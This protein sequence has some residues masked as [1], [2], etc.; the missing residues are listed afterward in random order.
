TDDFMENKHTPLDSPEDK[1]ESH[2]SAETAP[3]A[4]NSIHS[5][6]QPQEMEVHHHSHTPRKEF[7]HYAFEFFMLFLAV[8]CGFLAEYQLEHVIEHNR[9]EQY[10]Y[11]LAEDI[12]KDTAMLRYSI[13]YVD[14][15]IKKGMDSI[16]QII[17][18]DTYNDSASLLYALH[19]KYVRPM[20]IVFIDRT[21]QQLKNAGG[22]RLIRNSEVANAIS[23]YW[24]NIENTRLTLENYNN[25]RIGAKDIS[26]RIFN[27]KYYASSSDIANPVIT[28]T[29]VL[30]NNEQKVIGEY[31]N[32]VRHS[33]D[34]IDDFLLFSLRRTLKS[35]ENLLVLVSK[36][37]P[38]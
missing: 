19:M 26:Y 14:T 37:Y 24:A 17:Y 8:F 34:V 18:A 35:A 31:S 15:Y 1:A 21:T 2:R 12:K 27:S 9:E 28:G 13:N 6:S 20:R 16:L 11:S 32:R 7:K 5:E 29:A 33:R 23:L 10:M 4:F 25:I 3:D 36:E 22:M 30:M 38:D